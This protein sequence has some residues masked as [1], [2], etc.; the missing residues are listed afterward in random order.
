ML[1]YFKKNH[2]LLKK[3]HCSSTGMKP[4]TVWTKLCSF[5]RKQDRNLSPTNICLDGLAGGEL[6]VK[7]QTE[8]HNLLGD[9]ID[10]GEPF[11]INE[12]RTSPCF[13]FFLDVDLRV[14]DPGSQLSDAQL[15]QVVAVC[16][17]RLRD[18]FPTS[19]AS[20]FTVVVAG[21]AQGQS[22]STKS[23]NLHVHFPNLIVTS[24][25]ACSIA[26]DFANHLPALE[27]IT[28]N[29]IEA[30][31]HQVYLTNGLRML[32][33]SKPE[34]C[35]VKCKGARNDCV[36]CDNKGRINAGRVYGVRAC[37]TN[38]ARNSDWL[39]V[40]QK[41]HA[42]AIKTCSVRN[43]TAQQTSTGVR[44]STFTPVLKKRKAPVDLSGPAG[45]AQ[46]AIRSLGVR[47]AQ[48]D[49]SKFT[50]LKA[51]ELACVDVDGPGS[52]ACPNLLKGEHSNSR[53]YF[54]MSPRGISERCRCKKATTDN[55]KMPCSQYKSKWTP[56]SQDVVAK[57]FPNHT[58]SKINER[59]STIR[60]VGIGMNPCT[61][62][63]FE[64]YQQVLH[65]E[66]PTNKKPRNAKGSK[67]RKFEK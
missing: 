39:A 36:Q 46:Q 37:Y 16:I 43:E 12:L 54:L 27:G 11:F 31:D 58:T 56:M 55:R 66:P 29:W 28:S 18:T 44:V 20:T 50:E 67:R 57:L 2:W 65:G 48:L 62:R 15:D 41:N 13:P 10:R 47:Y 34:E 30:I 40:L 8:L 61:R 22:P 32:G 42:M 6:H 4:I 25:E 23:A 59:G 63:V 38:R 24:E 33:S 53:N 52:G 3:K 26:S 45:F 17:D 35:P 9:A 19:S 64:H 51:G 49:V 7:N 14:S 5:L 1:R 60:K 21:Q